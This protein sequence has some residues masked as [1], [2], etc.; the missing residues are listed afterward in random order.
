MTLLC[1]LTPQMSDLIFDHCQLGVCD[2][3]MATFYN[4]SFR[5]ANLT[6]ATMYKTSFM[7]CAIDDARLDN[8][9]LLVRKYEIEWTPLC[10]AISKDGK[11]I[12]LGCGNY[13]VVVSAET[14]KELKK[15]EAH[16]DVI[17]SVRF[18]KDSRSLVTV[19]DD[20]TLRSWD[21]TTF[22]SVIFKLP[23]KGGSVYYST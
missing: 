9:N 13:L 19:G 2:V 23:Q 1:H 7:H 17:R 16:L 10:C 5:S 6:N 11:Q 12:V 14:G 20:K 8:I 21:A 3:S 22:K 18:S 4:C 15:V